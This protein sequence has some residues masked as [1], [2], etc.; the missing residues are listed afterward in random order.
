MHTIPSNKHTNP[1]SQALTQILQD[2][3]ATDWQLGDFAGVDQLHLGG[4]SATKALAQ[5][6]PTNA[7]RGLDMGCG[8]GG[9]SRY[10]ALNHNCSMTGLDLNSDYIKGAQLINESLST[11]LE[12]GFIVGNSLTLPFAAGSFDFVVSQHATMNIAEKTKLLAGVHKVIKTGGCFLLHEVMLQAGC[13][14]ALVRYPTPWADAL[15]NSHL[16]HWQ[17]FANI[18]NAAGFRIAE[19]E[20]DTASSLAWINKAR[21]KKTHSNKPKPP[22]TPQL[23]LGPAAGEMSANVLENLQQG[24]LQVVSALLIKQ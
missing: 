8:L 10:L 24:R 5:W 2:H 20:D 1:L 15:D 11:K 19:F 23:A 14:E 17:T 6:L 4:I 18:A 13:D 3:M 7:K 22:F 12:C 9:T 21:N 16:N